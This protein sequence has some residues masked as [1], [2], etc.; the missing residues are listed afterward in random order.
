M[1]QPV[2]MKDLADSFLSRGRYTFTLA[3]AQELVGADEPASVYTGM[4]RLRKRHEVF[5]PA[6]GLYVAVPPEHR[7]R[8]V[9]PA[10]WFIDAMMRHLERPYY[11]CLLSAAAM[12]GAAHQAPQVFQVM[13]DKS[14]LVRKRNI[15]RFIR[16]RFYSNRHV[17]EEP[18]I[19]ITVPS[20]YVV[21][22]TK[23]TTV[24]DLVSRPGESAGLSNVATILG[25]LGEL[26]GSELARIASRRGRA[27]VRRVGWL[28]DRFGDVDDAEALRQAARLD[29]GEPVLLDPSKGRRGKADSTWQ[30]RVNTQIEAE[31]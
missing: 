31:A 20:G 16:L 5:S 9:V 15:D 17:T 6:H 3:E 8:G 18:T 24:V 30:V 23:E 10:E 25:D 7:T 22:A 4:S 1:P 28:V 12:H 11:V 14:N 29:L 27:L 19:R 2:P 26:K 21:V 13:T